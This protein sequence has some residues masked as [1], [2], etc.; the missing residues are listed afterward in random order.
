MGTIRTKLDSV[1]SSHPGS[2]MNPDE[3]E[4]ALALDRFK[5]MFQR[6]FPSCLEVLLVLK[7]LGYDKVS[8]NRD[9]KKLF[10]ERVRVIHEGECMRMRGSAN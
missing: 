2:E 8:E 5:K 6:P 7:S 9:V 1:N 4:F 3:I 10:N